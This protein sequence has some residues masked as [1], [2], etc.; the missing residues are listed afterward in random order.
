MNVAAGTR[1]GR[2]EIRSKIGKGGMGEVYLAEDLILHRRVAI[3][4]FSADSAKDARARKHLLRE[5]Q[6]AAKLDHPNIC[7]VHEVAEEDGRSF[8]VM[9]YVEGETLDI[10]IKTPRLQISESLALAVQIADALAE[11]HAH[12]IVHRDV[13]PSNIIITPRG[14]AKVMDFGLAKSEAAGL[15]VG[16]GIDAEA[17]T[18]PLLSTPGTVVGTVPYMSPE[19]LKGERLDARSDIFSFGTLLY[20]MLTGM[21]PFQADGGVATISAILTSDPR[22]LS[23]SCPVA[24]EDLERIVRKCLEKDRRIRYQS[25]REVAVDLA[26]A[27]R[28]CESGF[29]AAA[30]KPTETLMPAQQKPRKPNLISSR[31]G[32]IAGAVI[33]VIFG[34]AAY[35]FLSKGLRNAPNT[36]TA[37]SAVSDE[38]LRG[39]LN[40]RSQNRESNE[41]AIK[42]LEHVVQ[43][44]SM[45]AP[46]Y[47][48]LALAYGTK[49]QF[50]ATEAERKRLNEDARVDAEK[51]LSLNP[52]LAE[53]HFARG[54]LLWSPD[55]GFPH[56]LAIQSFKQAIALE[57]NL[58]EAHH[59]LGVVYF[60]IGLLDKAE[61]EIKEALRL[62]PSDNLA[63]FR[64]GSINVCRGKYEEAL[65]V[66]NHVPREVNPAIVDRARAVAFFELGRTEEASRIIEDYLKNYSTDE[67]GNVTSVKAMLF[68]K[69]GKQPEAEETIQHAIA[70]GK[71][72]QHF[73]HTEYNIAS[74]YAL[75]NRLDDAMTWLE[76]TADEGF[77]CYP[78]FAAD[79][80]LNNLQKNQR[81]LTFMAKLKHQWERYN[82]TV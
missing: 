55:N 8:I 36:A 25:M 13:K 21:Q 57:P 37:N 27:R 51:S 59:W 40:A 10:R 46:A 39:K 48:Q 77:P 61:N 35:W 2:Y 42:L 33:V 3:K 11:A 82:A 28:R 80:N 20:E 58:E 49:A 70:I 74:A 6:A 4:F 29:T 75:L 16:P 5:A 41:A 47:A 60:H 26:N 52:N 81:F 9:Q 69:A 19:Q 17:P 7:A 18:Q 14:Q 54:Y 50:F 56:A 38:Y 63:R 65:D 71:D 34:L 67:G 44:D 64:L 12:G 31:A 76:R 23:D 1:L 22:T 72:F 45:F 24:S 79:A 53:G 66:I 15:A 43:T 32:L 62:D 68:A 78:L 73:H 30:D